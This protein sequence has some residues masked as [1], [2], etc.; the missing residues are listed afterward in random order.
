MSN[1][2]PPITPDEIAA[3]IGTNTNN[4]FTTMLGLDVQAGPFDAASK[5][6]EEDGKVVCLVSFTGKWNGSGSISCS[7]PLACAFDEYGIISNAPRTA[8][9]PIVLRI[10]MICSL[11]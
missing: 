8:T 4:V 7:G 11:N 10:D 9:P 1:V 5:L 6:T 2:Q 3:I